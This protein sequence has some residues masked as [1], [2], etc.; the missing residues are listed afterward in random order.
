M[1]PACLAPSLRPAGERSSKGQGKQAA[2]RP[3]TI[4]CSRGP[5]WCP[6][7]QELIQRHTDELA[8]S[9]TQEQGKTLA[10]AR[11]D[12]FRGLGAALL[13]PPPPPLLLLLIFVRRCSVVLRGGRALW[14][15][16]RREHCVLQCLLPRP[17]LAAVCTSLRPAFHPRMSRGG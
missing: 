14:L 3:A 6:C 5:P 9:I 15:D 13:P 16:A 11:G 4:A 1:G 8:A 17:S 12:V 2:A 10:D 7:L